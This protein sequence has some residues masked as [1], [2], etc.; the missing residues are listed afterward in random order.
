[1]TYILE[2][3][4]RGFNVRDTETGLILY[5]QS[6]WEYP[7]LAEN[8]GAHILCDCGET[9]G[10]VD[11]DHTTASAMIEAAGNWLSDNDG[12]ETDSCFGAYPSEMWSVG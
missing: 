6:D 2:N 8:F 11:C 5:F 9:D 1:M 3:A 7:M 12:A 10:T 4:W